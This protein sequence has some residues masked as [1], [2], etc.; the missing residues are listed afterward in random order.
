MRRSS[1]RIALAVGIA[2][3]LFLRL[4]IIGAQAQH[5]KDPAGTWL[6]ALVVFV[7][8]V[9][10]AWLFLAILRARGRLRNQRVLI[11]NPGALLVSGTKNPVFEV[12]LLKLGVTRHLSTSFVWAV[13][14]AGLSFWQ[15]PAPTLIADFP[16]NVVLDIVEDDVE[17]GGRQFRGITIRIRCSSS[18]ESV[19]FIARNPEH[20]MMPLDSRRISK[21]LKLVEQARG[22]G[23]QVAD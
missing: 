8:I 12:A 22:Q 6:T 14:Q 18:I 13:D 9:G 4:L 21:L 11:K 10:L 5:S 15:G 19:N 1:A 16:W 20:P 17:G 2:G 23:S 3:M 7:V